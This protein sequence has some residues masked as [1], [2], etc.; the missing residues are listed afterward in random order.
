MNRGVG[1][2]AAAGTADHLTSVIAVIDVD[3]AVDE[4][5]TPESWLPGLDLFTERD[6]YTEWSQS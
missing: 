2:V 3:S 1:Y 4:D 5:G 6:A